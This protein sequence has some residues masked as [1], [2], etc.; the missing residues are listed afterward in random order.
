ME[1]QKKKETRNK[2]LNKGLNCPRQR[3][4]STDFHIPTLDEL[5]GKT[6]I[7]EWKNKYKFGMIEIT[8]EKEWKN[9]DNNAEPDKT[10]SSKDL[11]PRGTDIEGPNLD[12]LDLM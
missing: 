6:R 12:D 7:N 4:R 5:A 10:I 11:I 1:Q 8:R 2:L 9:K 3:G